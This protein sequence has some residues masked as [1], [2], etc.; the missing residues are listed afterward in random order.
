MVNPAWKLSLAA[1]V[2][3]SAIAG[4]TPIAQAFTLVTSSSALASDDFV[5]WGSFGSSFTLVPSG[6]Q[7]PSSV[8][9]LV[10]VSLPSSDAF[11]R[12]DQGNG[13]AGNFA[14]GAQLLWTQVN[15]GP[16]SIVFDT[17]V[18]GAGA[19]I[20][21]NIPPNGV[22]TFTAFAEGFD[23]SNNSLGSV[24]LPGLSNNLGN[25]SAIFI[26]AVSDIPIARFI[27]SVE[28][29]D[30]GDRDF[31]IGQLDMRQVPLPPQAA[32]SLLCMTL[33]A[34]KLRRQAK[35]QRAA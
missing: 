4:P 27:F 13:W 21:L 20:Q 3:A 35:K 24:S 12:R 1:L 25:N 6:S 10:T 23:S 30:G 32:G 22:R 11:S 14:P 2:A 29:T 5:S 8:G 34:I 26:G 15:P 28:P 7:T 19:Q 31:A 9:N 16:L 18:L 33:S 17:P